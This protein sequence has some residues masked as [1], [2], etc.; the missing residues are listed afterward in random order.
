MRKKGFTLIELLV[1]IAIIGLLLAII[2]PG[3]QKARYLV[4]RVYCTNNIKGQALI[5][6][7]YAT[8]YDGKFHSHNDW[9]PEYVRS[10]GTLDSLYDA[11]IGYVDE[12]K[13]MSCPIQ[14]LAAKPGSDVAWLDLYWY[15]G[16]SGYANW[17]ALYEDSSRNPPNIL[18]GYL[19]FANYTNVA[20]SS[21]E[22]EFDF[23]DTRGTPS[24]GMPWPKTDAQAS[25]NTAFIA[26]RISDTPDA[27]GGHFW[28]T[29]HGG[30]GLALNTEIDIFASD[31]DNPVG[32]GDGHVEVTLKRQIKPRARTSV[33]VYYY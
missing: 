24:E 11:I 4:R 21:A 26:H 20:N 18:S 6:K 5:Q 8:D 22:P 13:I 33:G 2:V 28:D 32:Y 12:V 10:S 25:A 3:L 7:L 31:V 17:G 1:V 30:A 27:S 16:T 19:W 29:A 23:V 9:S 15:D 14:K